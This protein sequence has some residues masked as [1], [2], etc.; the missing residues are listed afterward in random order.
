M[1]EIK[2]RYHDKPEKINQD[3]QRYDRQESFSLY[4]LVIYKTKIR[5][6]ANIL[7]AK[8]FKHNRMSLLC[9]FM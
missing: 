8:I 5:I 2:K 7:G 6:K 9:I 1:V 4:S 3:F